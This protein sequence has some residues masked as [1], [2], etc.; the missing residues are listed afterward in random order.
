[1]YVAVDSGD[2]EGVVGVQ[3]A[4]GNWLPAVATDER[5]RDQLR[6]I[7]EGIARESGREIRLLCFS[8]REDLGV[9]KAGS[10]PPESPPGGADVE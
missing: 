6:P 5:R 8:V 7:V 10:V 4:D 9:I 2:S 3:T 1:M